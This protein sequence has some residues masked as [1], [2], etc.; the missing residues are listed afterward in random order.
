MGNGL[1]PRERGEYEV[2]GKP[3]LLLGEEGTRGDG[4]QVLPPG[5]GEREVMGN[6]LLCQERGKCKKG[7]ICSSIGKEGKME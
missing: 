2:M 6:R 1:F 4:E 5:E 7:G 3:A